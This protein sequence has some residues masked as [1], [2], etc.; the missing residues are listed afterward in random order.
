MTGIVTLAL[1]KV[2]LCRLWP[3]L[4]AFTPAPEL[5]LMTAPNKPM[6][7]TPHN[8]NQPLRPAEITVSSR[9]VV[10]SELL[11]REMRN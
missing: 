10:R 2:S 1:V 3:C 9:C 5:E 6:S 11:V 7:L 8:R 4:K